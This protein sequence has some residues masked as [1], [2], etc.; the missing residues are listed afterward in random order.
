MTL[1]NTP[2][3][4]GRATWHQFVTPLQWVGLP[5]RVVTEQFLTRESPLLS[6][7]YYD[8][9]PES[10]GTYSTS[11]QKIT[12]NPKP[13]GL[14]N[15]VF[16]HP[17]LQVFVVPARPC[18][19]SSRFVSTQEPFAPTNHPGG[20]PSRRGPDRWRTVSDP[21]GGWK[22]VP[23]SYQVAVSWKC[24]C[25]CRE[26]P[27]FRGCVVLPGPKIRVQSQ[28]AWA[29]LFNANRSCQSLP[30][31]SHLD[32]VSTAAGPPGDHVA[33]AFRFAPSD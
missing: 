33:E 15:M 9:S 7:K 23:G 2:A 20:R 22:I 19:P 3:S 21:A 8:S 28:L 31:L 27:F 30:G 6:G 25:K 24:A 13:A 4:T 11:L 5:C 29:D 14:R 16:N 32:P 1:R 18:S 12:W 17:G 26:S 10:R